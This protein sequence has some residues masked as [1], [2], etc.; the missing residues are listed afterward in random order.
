VK[1]CI[2]FIGGRSIPRTGY[3][4]LPNIKSNTENKCIESRNLTFSQ[5]HMKEA[6]V[7]QRHCCQ[8]FQRTEKMAGEYR[9]YSNGYSKTACQSI[10]KDQFLHLPAKRSPS[11]TSPYL[12][13]TIAIHRDRSIL[14][15]HN[16][17]LQVSQ[18]HER[19]ATSLG[20]WSTSA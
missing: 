5:L 13:L 9:N 15:E 4:Y 10:P 14:D 19:T 1:Q 18:L 20:C 8:E 6:H 3:L 16:I 17:L 11:P 7:N 2:R 12:H